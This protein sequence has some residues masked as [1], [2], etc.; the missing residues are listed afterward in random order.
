MGIKH[1]VM[2]TGDT[3]KTAERIAQEASIDEFGADLLPEDK[4]EYLKK[5]KAEGR[6]IAMVGDGINDSPALNLADVGLAMGQGSDIAKEVADIV[7]SDTNLRS[8]INLR[9]LSEGLT[10]RLTSS[11]KNVMCFNSGLLAL[12]ITGVIT[13]QASSFLHNASTIG[14]GLRNTRSYLPSQKKREGTETKAKPE[15]RL[16]AKPKDEP[17][18]KLKGVP[19]TLPKDKTSTP[20]KKTKE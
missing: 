8:L 16:S 19:K 18:A 15:A 10:E 20:P 17:K 12:G 6:T 3:Y 2:L 7:L 13:P 4:Y 1:V 9:I 11:F 5:L 14:F